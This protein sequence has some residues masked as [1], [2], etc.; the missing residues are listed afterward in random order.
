M[1]VLGRKGG[2]EELKRLTIK[3]VR[4]VKLLLQVDLL[5]VVIRR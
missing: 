4:C 5:V 3:D 2:R 1:K